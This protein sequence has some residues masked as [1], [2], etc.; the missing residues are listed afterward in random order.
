[1]IIPVTAFLIFLLFM[2]QILSLVYTPGSVAN[3]DA[4]T[5]YSNLDS[6]DIKGPIVYG[7]FSLLIHLILFFILFTKLQGVSSESS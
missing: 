5:K 1:M 6:S 3:P 4:K 2:F 7:T